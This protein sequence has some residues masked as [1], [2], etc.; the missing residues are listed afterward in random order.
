MLD[1]RW[2]TTF[3]VL[4][5]TGHFT[6]TANRLHMTQPGVSQHL[7]KLE[8]EVGKPL[9][10]QHGK[11]FSLTPAGEAVRAL[12]QAWQ[13]EETRLRETLMFD[14]ADS[15]RVAVA[16]SGS[17]A[18]LLYPA[19]IEEMAEAPAL[20]ISYEAAP[21]HRVLD[22]VVDG[23]FDLGIVGYD[24]D[25]PRLDCH[26]LGREELCLVLPQNGRC[27]GFSLQD[28]DACGLIAH[29]DVFA[30][31]DV[32]FSANFPSAFRGSDRLKVRSTIN[33]ISQ[34][35]EPVASGIGYTILPRSGVLPYPQQD[36]LFIADLNERIYLD[37]WLLSRRGRLSV[38]RIQRIANM[39]QG[40]A[41]KLAA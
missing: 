28:L 17:F 40:V 35:L 16:S 10:F 13:H 41:G 37:L 26:Y 5:E 29:P 30:Y 8:A 22:G 32:L 6:N 21:Q 18:T 14:R 7:R 11:S 25:H 24:P 38:A 20:E 36:R 19:L 9:I 34:I 15:G 33:Q 3:L 12:G 31:A 23:R 39:I 1:S 27:R 2:L 4:C